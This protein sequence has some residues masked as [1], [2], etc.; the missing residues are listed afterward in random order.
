MN[1]LTELSPVATE[2]LAHLQEDAGVGS[3]RMREGD[4]AA[5]LLYIHELLFDAPKSWAHFDRVEVLFSAAPVAREP[6]DQERAE[7]IVSDGLDSLTNE[8]LAQLFLARRALDELCVLLCLRGPKWC[9]PAFAAIGAALKPRSK[10]NS[11]QTPVAS[12]EKA[13]ASISKPPTDTL[14]AVEHSRRWYVNPSRILPERGV[15]TGEPHF[16]EAVARNW[17]PILYQNERRKVRAADF[18]PH[19]LG[20]PRFF[21]FAEQPLSIVQL[22]DLGV[23]DH[24]R[25]WGTL[26]PFLR[27]TNELHFLTCAHVF[28]EHVSPLGS[29]IWDRTS[30][31]LRLATLPD[32]PELLKL[33]SGSDVPT[34][35]IL[36]RARSDSRVSDDLTETADT[37]GFGN[38]RVREWN[39]NATGEFLSFWNERHEGTLIP[40]DLKG[41]QR[42][43]ALRFVGNSYAPFLGDWVCFLATAPPIGGED[44]C[45]SRLAWLLARV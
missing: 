28:S 8:E 35:P 4:R 37:Y 10:Q 17:I 42:L 34:K 15:P 13:A 32:L 31:F 2:L 23:A 36:A 19:H 11:H 40:F 16:A 21:G 38:I 33:G 26:G 30:S 1:N 39:A 14:P 3:L 7:M 29:E 41:L 45:V 24:F 27:G 12:A 44:P 5:A 18:R 22:I 20:V 43:R 25:H 9:E 6:L